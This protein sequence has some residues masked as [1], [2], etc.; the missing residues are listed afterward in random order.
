MTTAESYPNDDA[1]RKCGKCGELRP[2]DDG[3]R[4]HRRQCPDCRAACQVAYN[5]EY[6]AANAD[7]ERARH[8]AYR[9]ANADKVRARYKAY[10]QTEAGKQSM[11]RRSRNRRAVKQNAVCA[12]GPNCFDNAA[13]L[14]PRKCA[15]PGCRRRRPEA[16]HI[17]PLAEGGLH[18]RHNLQPLCKSCNSAKSAR[19]VDAAATGYLL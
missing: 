7:K 18:C 13:R 12:H 16:D 4:W 9:A 5:A 14:M 8:K 10:C 6:R 2:T 3:R 11:R 15:T 17:I 1:F 19:L